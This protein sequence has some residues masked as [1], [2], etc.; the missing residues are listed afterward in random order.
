MQMRRYGLSDGQR[1][2]I[3]DLLPIRE[4]HV[5]GTAADNRLFIDAVLYRYHAGILGVICQRASGTGRTFT[6]C[7]VIDAIAM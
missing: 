7:C 1:D 6:G 5:G 3:K 4:S 2:R